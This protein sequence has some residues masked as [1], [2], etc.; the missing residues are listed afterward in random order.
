MLD[1]FTAA[2]EYSVMVALFQHRNEVTSM[3]H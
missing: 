3:N 1:K 2:R